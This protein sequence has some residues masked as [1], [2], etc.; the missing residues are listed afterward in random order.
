MMN[1]QNIPPTGGNTHRQAYQQTIAQILEQKQTQPEGL[2]QAEAVER[3]QKLGPNA[4]PQKKGKPAWLRF[5]A[6]F[7][8]VLIYILLAAAV[9]TAVMG[10]WVDTAVIL[11]VTVINALIGYIQESN[12]EK[13]LQ[14]IRNMLSSDAQVIRDGK[15]ATI[16]TTDLVPGDIV[17]LRAGDRIPADMRLIEAHNLRVEEAILTGESTVVDKHTDALTGDLPLGDRTNMLFSGTTVSAG[18]GVGV[19]VATG[20][21]TEL[22]RINQM[23]ADVETNRTPLLVQMD[24]L[25]KAIFVIILAMM[26]VL[27][28]FSVLLRDMPMGELLLSLIS[29]A[30][31]AVPEGLPAIISIILSLGVQAMARKRAIIRKLPTVETLGAMTV[32]CSDKTGTLTMNEMTV[33]AVITADSCYRV[34]GDSYEPVGNLYLEGSNEPVK[35]QPYTVLEKYL[36]T[37]DLCNDSQLVRNELGHWGITGGPTEGAL[38]VL[39]TK[40]SLEPVTTQLVAK[41]PFDSQYKYMAT[42][43]KLDAEEWVMVTGAPDVLFALCEQQQTARGLA[44]F[45]RTYWESEMERFARQGLRMVAAAIKPADIGAT[46]L[47]HSD[48]QQ[49]LIFL[50]IAG[51]MDPP[52][53]EAVDAIHTC[54]TAGI[55]VKMIT[56]DHPQTAMSIG[57]MLGIH[58]S[59]EAMTGY[60]LEHMDDDELAKAAVEYDIFARTS[61]EHKLRLVKALQK[62]GEVVGM[63]GDGVNDAPALRQADVGIAMGIKGTEVTKEAADMVLTDDNFATIASSVKEGRRVYDNLKKTIL[64]IMPTNLA[65]GLL[66]VIALLAGNMIPLTPVLILWM[67]MA[68]SATLSFGLAF[69]AA[70]RNVMNRPPRKTGQHVMD[71]FAV[72][73]VAFVGSM[74]AIS[75]F[76]LEAWLAPRGHSAEFVRT[77]LLQMLVTAQWLYMVNC[78]NTDGF[79]INRGL[80]KNKG[81][82]MVTGVLL[83]L[84]L[85]IIYLPVMQMMFGTEALPA[86]YW[87]VTLA[88][89][90]VMFFIVEIEKRLTRRFRKAA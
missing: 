7:N 54:Q 69:E 26:A 3:L 60:Q 86:R 89:G 68:T 11:G 67:N 57:Q 62:N 83:L 39:A 45:D 42:H 71:A 50:G 20:Q 25:G 28:V 13:S 78:R 6:H 35:V 27:F 37:I 80:L 2:N 43:Y 75:A 23:M 82:W 16:P 73:R 10:H 40:A 38:K 61:P 64:F 56:G 17:V 1:P 29:L 53:P 12:A 30:V 21:A 51:M 90:A 74:I 47:D 18:G 59:T 77:V 79:S 85:A 24:K 48:L 4:L 84:Q 33:K 14:S 15:H 81:I 55:R 34:D 76:I 65:Q 58:N 46:T 31:A 72:W 49:G 44:T 63:T 19:V 87:F 8:D 9:M 88:M 5:L 41:I 22:G 66:V 52:R 36:R 70:E 32:V